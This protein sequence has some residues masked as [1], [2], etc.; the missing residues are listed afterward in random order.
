MLQEAPAPQVEIDVIPE[1]GTLTC[2]LFRDQF[3]LLT[4]KESPPPPIIPEDQHKDL[5]EQILSPPPE[6]EQ[7]RSPGHFSGFVCFM[8]HI[9]MVL[10]PNALALSSMECCPTMVRTGQTIVVSNAADSWRALSMIFAIFKRFLTIRTM[11][12]SQSLSL[13]LI[14]LMIDGCTQAEGL[15][16]EKDEND[17]ELEDQIDVSPLTIES[18]PSP[19]K[20]V[21]LP[22]KL[23]PIVK[24]N[25]PKKKGTFVYMSQ[26]PAKHHAEPA[27]V[28]EREVVPKKPATLPTKPARKAPKTEVVLPAKP[29][30]LPVIATPRS[31][32]PLKEKEDLTPPML[33][34]PPDLSVER[35]ISA[36]RASSARSIKLPEP[37]QIVIVAPT[38]LPLLDSPPA[39][40]EVLRPQS[41]LGTFS[42]SVTSSPKMKKKRVIRAVEHQPEHQPKQPAEPVAVEVPESIIDVIDD[43]ELTI[44]VTNEAATVEQK[45]AQPAAQPAASLLKMG[46]TSPFRLRRRY[47]ANGSTSPEQS[48]RLDLNMFPLTLDEEQ[49][50][51]VMYTWLSQFAIL[52]EAK[53]AQFAKVFAYFDTDKDQQLSPDEVWL[54]IHM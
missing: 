22:A 13:L 42:S 47:H 51:N 17:D 31:I 7:A 39:S 8:S 48:R 46:A 11:F 15:E 49:G 6:P 33:L 19:K 54:I 2:C 43:P 1:P 5:T 26:M 53:R 38:P 37:P 16:T 10:V 23:P 40:E 9:R 29:E 36:P 14:L 28:K 3:D 18:K 52:T 45:P 25:P 41:P 44:N 24:Q 4:P 35:P 20:P 50:A 27:P 21:K 32:T 12:E 30:P 34:K